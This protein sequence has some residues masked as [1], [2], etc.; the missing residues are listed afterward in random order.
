MTGQLGAGVL[1]VLPGSGD[2]D[3]ELI[4]LA[5]SARKAARRLGRLTGRD[6]PADRFVE[7]DVA[8]PGWGIGADDLERIADVDAVVNLAGNTNWAASRRSHHAANTLGAIHGYEL[9]RRLRARDGRTALYLYASS[10]HAAGGLEGWVPE[11]PLAPDGGRTPYEHS[12]WLAEQALIDPSRRR[13]G[14]AVLIARIGGLVGNSQTGHTVRRNS[15]YLMPE[16]WHRAP[17]NV[18]PINPRGRVDMLPRDLAAGAMLRALRGALVRGDDEPAIVHVAAGETAP[19]I[20]SLLRTLRAI[21]V[22]QTMIMPRVAPVP[23]RLMVSTLD[24]FQRFRPLDE[25]W[26][27]VLTGIRYMTFERLFERHGLARLV[28]DDL[29][30]LSTERLVRLVFDPPPAEPVA[31]PADASLAR[32]AA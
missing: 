22:H 29:P 32:F 11:A 1:D 16:A 15:L 27:N 5:R 14:P 31:P 24:Q 23:G 25:L 2:G 13:D 30:S 21:D 18:L 6:W 20:E 10:I 8:Q 9:T 26:R 17:L 7:G 28:G 19:T 12:K 4:V 3:P